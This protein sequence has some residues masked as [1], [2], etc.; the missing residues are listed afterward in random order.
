MSPQNLPLPGT[1]A[2]TSQRP[3]SS[4]ECKRAA[5]D[6]QRGTVKRL[7]RREQLQNF[8]GQLDLVLRRVTVRKFLPFI[9]R[10]APRKRPRQRVALGTHVQQGF[11]CRC[12]FI[13]NPGAPARTSP[14]YF[15]P[16]TSRAYRRDTGRCHAPPPAS[17][18]C[19]TS[20]TCA[21]ERPANPPAWRVSTRCAACYRGRH[22]CGRFRTGQSR[23]D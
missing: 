4:G 15:L 22:W 7:G 18:S 23:F 6:D 17:W 8:I 14:V 1:C 2:V 12:S 3:V 5:H 16:V 11:I 19:D 20:A 10:P 21:S 9:R 13:V